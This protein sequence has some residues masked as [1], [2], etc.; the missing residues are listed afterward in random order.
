MKL[1]DIIYL[2]IAVVLFMA[3]GILYTM[4]YGAQNKYVYVDVQRLANGYKGMQNAKKEFEAK[5]ETWKVNLDTLR[6]EAELKIKEYEATGAKLSARDKRAMEEMIQSKQQQYAEYQQAITE[7]MQKEDQ[8][9]TSK[10]LSEMND[11]I[12]KIGKQRGYTIIMAATQ[13]GNIVYA[14][15][16]ADITDE[17]LEGLNASYK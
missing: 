8:E 6:R 16:G 1:K 14:S 7:K 12:K 11:Q 13:Y 4:H 3:V 17:V 5:T 9:M 10:V 15:E 2:V